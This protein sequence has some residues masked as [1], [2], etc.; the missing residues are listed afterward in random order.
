MTKISSKKERKKGQKKKRAHQ[1]PLPKKGSP[2][3]A[4][5]SQPF[6][7][8]L[9]PNSLCTTVLSS[10]VYVNIRFVLGKSLLVLVL[11]ITTPDLL[12]NPDRVCSADVFA[13]SRTSLS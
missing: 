8:P 2:R 6:F 10:L 5:D 7:P 9:L 4:L 1:Q 3:S 12:A 13:P 11:A